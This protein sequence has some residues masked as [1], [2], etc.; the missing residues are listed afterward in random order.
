MSK[1]KCKKI[2]GWALF[3]CGI[4]GG[5]FVFLSPIGNLFA[6]V[7]SLLDL[8]SNPKTWILV[9]AVL[10]IFFGWDLAHFD[11]TTGRDSLSKEETQYQV[12]KSMAILQCISERSGVHESQGKFYY[13]FDIG[14]K[15]PANSGCL[16]CALQEE[17]YKIH[18]IVDRLLYRRLRAKEDEFKQLENA[19]AK[20]TKKS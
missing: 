10:A 7:S 20:V 9:P 8:L 15:P 6:L 11:K 2:L 1:M 13:N 12:D 5:V 3:A 4:I 16:G 17:C 18:K 19:R 14:K